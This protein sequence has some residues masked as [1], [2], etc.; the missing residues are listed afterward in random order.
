MKYVVYVTWD[1]HT[2]KFYIG[3]T[4]ETKLLRGYRGSGN[5][6]RAAVQ[7][8]ND[9]RTER[10]ATFE[11]EAEAYEFEEF[12]VTLL[13]GDPLC[14]NLISG[15]RGV[16]SNFARS[17]AIK[18]WESPEYRSAGL[19]QLKA[20]HATPEHAERLRQHNTEQWADPER[21]AK[22][23]EG[24]RARAK[25]PAHKAKTIAGLT[26]WRATQQGAEKL[27]DNAKKARA[28]TWGNPEVAEKLRAHLRAMNAARWAQ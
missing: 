17:S 13:R 7:A 8:E 10:V 2:G 1:L 14:K 28:N 5:W 24:M 27:K 12:C 21:R 15:G 22:L 16:D 23:L 20:V 26:R 25:D 19:A 4:Y 9:L 3:K 11:T 6:V 18:R